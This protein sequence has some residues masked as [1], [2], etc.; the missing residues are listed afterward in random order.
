MRQP[1]G[2]SENEYD[3]L[4]AI[5]PANAW[6]D[7]ALNRKSKQLR[8]RLGGFPLFVQQHPMYDADRERILH[9]HALGVPLATIADVRLKYGKYLSLK[10]YLTKLQRQPSRNASA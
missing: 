6:F 5:P 8:V 9:L 3:I 7:K 1:K 2:S 10:N 4:L